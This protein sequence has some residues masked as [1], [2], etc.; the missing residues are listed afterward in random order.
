MSQIL[1]TCAIVVKKWNRWFELCAFSSLDSVK[2]G[3][4][5]S[6]GDLRNGIVS[7]PGKLRLSARVVLE[8]KGKDVFLH[9]IYTH[10][11]KNLSSHA[12]CTCEKAFL[13]FETLLSISK[14]EAP[15]T[16]AI[17]GLP[18]TMAFTPLESSFGYAT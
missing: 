14:L 15:I 11:G 5:G 6:T 1:Y 12:T 8:M 13:N 9:V 17:A 7:K 4:L 10:R 2:L 18:F 3:A 16:H